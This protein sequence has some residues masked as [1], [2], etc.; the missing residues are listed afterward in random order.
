MI[1]RFLPRGLWGL[2]YWYTLL[3][4][5]IWIFSGVL[6]TIA[7]RVGRPVIQGPEK[8]GPGDQDLST[9]RK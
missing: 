5:H 2:L 8:F 3:P 1:G 9:A 4:F 6:R 7:E